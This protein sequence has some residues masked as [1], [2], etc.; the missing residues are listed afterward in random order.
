MRDICTH[1]VKRTERLIVRRGADIQEESSLEKRNAYKIRSFQ[2]AINAI[3]AL[4]YPITSGKD[5]EKVRRG[6]LR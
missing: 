4:D 5:A 6:F 1:G 2:I 3:K